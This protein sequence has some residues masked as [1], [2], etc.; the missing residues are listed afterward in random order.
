MPNVDR[1]SLFSKSVSNVGSGLQSA[2]LNEKINFDQYPDNV[3]TMADDGL[4]FKFMVD[5]FQATFPGFPFNG[6][7][8]KIILFAPRVMGILSGFS[9]VYF[10]TFFKQAGSIQSQGGTF[11]SAPNFFNVASLGG[12]QLPC[13]P[14]QSVPGLG[15]GSGICSGIKFN[16]NGSVAFTLPAFPSFAAQGNETLFELH[17]YP[18]QG[19][20]YQLNYG[21]WISS[22]PSYQPLA[23]IDPK[24]RRIF[25]DS[26]FV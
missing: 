7:T 13:G 23:Q 4:I 22:G 2:G 25:P 14:G 16:Y 17:T 11:V 5:D 1:L 15:V 26:W 18:L 12:I 8:V 24:F 19:L 21:R 3:A 6:V 9:F 10:G 20:F